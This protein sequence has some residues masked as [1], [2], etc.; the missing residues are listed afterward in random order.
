MTNSNLT[1]I[2]VI[3]DR[4]GSMAETKDDMEKGLDVFFEEQRK[5]PGDVKVSLFQFDDRYEVVYENVKL[6]DVTTHKIEPW[7]ST[8][9]LDAIGKSFDRVG[10]QLAAQDDS[11]RP[12][13]IQWLIV[14]DGMENFSHEYTLDRVTE[15]IKVQR[16]EYQWQIDF[17]GSN[18]DA[19]ATAAAMGIRGSNALTY[20]NGGVNALRAT[21]GKF[22]GLRA[23]VAGGQSVYAASAAVADY[24]TEDV[25][26]EAMKPDTDKTDED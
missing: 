17:L 19:I 26:A 16:D 15:M 14:T 1:H 7:G 9:L 4:S 22:S 18:Q 11:Q 25:R 10:A 20:G 13:L 8:A 21:G 12:G 24:Y 6:E 5:V 2:Y 3:L 23:N